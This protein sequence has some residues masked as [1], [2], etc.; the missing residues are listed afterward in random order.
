MSLAQTVLSGP[1]AQ[2]QPAY[3]QHRV[4]ISSKIQI[5]Q[6]NKTAINKPR[7]PMRKKCTGCN[8]KRLNRQE[9][10]EKAIDQMVEYRRQEEEEEKLKQ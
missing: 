8:K 9:L 10:Y 7:S 1:E 5:N 3:Q 4:T 2:Q 6:Y